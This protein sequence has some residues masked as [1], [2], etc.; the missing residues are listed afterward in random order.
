MMRLFTA[1]ATGLSLRGAKH[2]LCTLTSSYLTWSCEPQIMT[3]KLQGSRKPLTAGPDSSSTI[4][5]SAAQTNVPEG[6]IWR[7]LAP[8]SL[9]PA[10]PLNLKR[11]FHDPWQT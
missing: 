10:G 4:A 5:N 7:Y 11:S 8:D 6:A 3:C 9:A 2:V 1:L